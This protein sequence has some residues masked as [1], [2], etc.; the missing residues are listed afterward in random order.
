MTMIENTLLAKKKKKITKSIW[1]DDVNTVHVF[2]GRGRNKEKDALIHVF[3]I[4]GEFRR[5]EFGRSHP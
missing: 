2:I 1:L 5:C 3:C 4:W